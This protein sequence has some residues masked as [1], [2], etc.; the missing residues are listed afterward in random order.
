MKLELAQYREMLSFSQIASDL[1]ESAQ[2]LLK[3]GV[4]ITEVLKQKKEK[5]LSFPQEFIVIYAVLNG[6]FDNLEP[7]MIQKCEEALFQSLEEEN[8]H[9]TDLIEEREKLSDEDISLLNDFLR[10]FVTNFLSKSEK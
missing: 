7:S 9:I 8:Y 6:Y 10:D 4:R 3:R 2:S 1:D 5:P